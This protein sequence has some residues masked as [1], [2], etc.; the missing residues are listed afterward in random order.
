MFGKNDVFSFIILYVYIPLLH[1][2]LESDVTTK[3]MCTD[4]LMVATYSLPIEANGEGGEGGG[5]QRTENLRD[6]FEVKT[7]E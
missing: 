6:N 7:V 1:H 3:Y 2:R 5:G 4:F